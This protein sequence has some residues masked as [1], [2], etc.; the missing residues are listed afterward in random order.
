VS[1][2]PK[3]LPD[4]AGRT[5]AVT[6]GNAGIGYVISEQIAA[7]GGH[8]LVLGRNPDR[9]R[10]AI[11]SIGRHVVGARVTAIP[12]DLAD[13]ESVASAAAVLTGLDRLDALI[14][15]AGIRPGTPDH[16]A[17]LRARRGNQPPRPLRA[18]RTGHARP[19]RH[20]GQPGRADRQHHDQVREVRP[21][22]P[23]ERSFLR[24]A[25]GV[26]QWTQLTLTRRDTPVSRSR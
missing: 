14:Q 19:V 15:N 4:L 3:A 9:V 20:T 16:R 7:A 18:H 25:E 6:G 11:E 22:G 17:G 12:L 23:T 2:N 26:I 1:R 21:R 10:A 5:Y 8:V 24:P 13:L